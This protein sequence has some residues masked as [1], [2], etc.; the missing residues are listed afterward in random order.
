MRNPFSTNPS[1]SQAR[2]IV[3]I[4]SSNRLLFVLPTGAGPSRSGSAGG[5]RGSDRMPDRAGRLDLLPSGSNRA[6]APGCGPRAA[7]RAPGHRGEVPRRPRS[8]FSPFDSADASGLGAGPVK[9]WIEARPNRARITSRRDGSGRRAESST[10]R[11][12][13]PGG[14]KGPITRDLSENGSIKARLTP[15]ERAV[16]GRPCDPCSFQHFRLER[17][18]ASWYKSGPSRARNPRTMSGQ[19]LSTE[20]T[21]RTSITRPPP[22]RA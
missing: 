9:V 20:V 16:Q 18:L 4:Q 11:P 6:A 5:H 13:R 14:R 21:C 15:V 1:D 8:P 3:P 2:W 17:R 22:T 10:T 12:T 7:R 19:A